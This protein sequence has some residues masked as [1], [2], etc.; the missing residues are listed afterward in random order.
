VLRG[1]ADAQHLTKGQLSPRAVPLY[2]AAHRYRAPLVLIA[3]AG[4]FPPN[5][6]LDAA[7]RAGIHAIA[8]ARLHDNR[9]SG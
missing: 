2:N 9:Q 3:I 1:A 6:D 5:A 7:W 8:L 4:R